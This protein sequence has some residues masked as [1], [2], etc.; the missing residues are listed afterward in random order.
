MSQSPPER[1]DNHLHDGTGTGNLAHGHGVA[2][3]KVQPHLNIRRTTPIS[4]SSVGD[5]AGVNGQ[6]T[7]PASQPLRWAPRADGSRSLQKIKVTTNAP[8]GVEISGCAFMRGFRPFRYVPDFLVAAFTTRTG[9]P[10]LRTTDSA[11]LPST[12]RCM[13]RRPFVPITMRS[14]ITR[15][16]WSRMTSTGFPGSEILSKTN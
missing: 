8:I 10:A 12:R 2:D 11:T 1:C 4:V 3:R 9:H 5:K 15:F 16:A 13:P 6:T 7:T 14:A